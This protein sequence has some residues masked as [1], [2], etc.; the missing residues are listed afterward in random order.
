MYNG[1]A[2]MIEE[3]LKLQKPVLE[4][5]SLFKHLQAVGVFTAEQDSHSE[6]N[7][8]AAAAVSRA[9]KKKGIREKDNILTLVK[10]I[11]ANKDGW[12]VHDILHVL[13]LEAKGELKEKSGFQVFGEGMFSSM[14]EAADAVVAAVAAKPFMCGSHM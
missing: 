3:E 10:Q 2:A 8:A 6:I 7:E 5:E 4:H 12:N 9:L 14:K 11:G 13:I 1:V